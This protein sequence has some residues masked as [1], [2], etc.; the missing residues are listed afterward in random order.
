[1]R[2][3]DLVVTC[4]RLSG[5]A[6]D[7]PDPILI[8]EV[9]SDSTTALDRGAKRREYA[10]LPSLRRYV[11]LVQEEPLALVCERDDGFAERRVRDAVH[12]PEFDLSIP[13]A[14]LHAGLPRYEP[15][16]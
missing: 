10:A 2:Y 5:R 4:S 3:P 9:L 7:V 11:M 15:D 16:A 1:M 12:L 13:L 6:L 8:V 14:D